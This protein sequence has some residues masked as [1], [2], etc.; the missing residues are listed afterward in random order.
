M[1]V[2]EEWLIGTTLKMWRGRKK[3]KKNTVWAPHANHKEQLSLQINL[4][5]FSSEHERKKL[6]GVNNSPPVSDG[7]PAEFWL[8][9][10]LYIRLSSI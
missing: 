6:K 4:D 7:Q 1:S 10:E 3:N 8:V 2:D 9:H 5:I